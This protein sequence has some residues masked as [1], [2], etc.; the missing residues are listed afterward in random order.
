MSF[1]IETKYGP[2]VIY[3]SQAEVDT[4]DYDDCVRWLK[5]NDHNGCYEKEDQMAEFG[6]LASLEDMRQLVLDQCEDC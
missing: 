4:L 3:K 1:T 2:M 6:E 5:F